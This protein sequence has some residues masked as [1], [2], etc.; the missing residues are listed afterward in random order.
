MW[1]YSKKKSVWVNLSM[2]QRI[3]KDGNGGY[4]ITCLDGVSTVIDQEEYN[5]SMHW[6]DPNWYDK[7]PNGSSLNIEEAIK[8]IMKATNAKIEDKKEGGD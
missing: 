3:S 1:I 2:A 7:H 6:V 8:A 4:L 5:Q